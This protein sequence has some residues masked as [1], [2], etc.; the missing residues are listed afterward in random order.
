[1]GLFRNVLISFLVSMLAVTTAFAQVTILPAVGPDVDCEFILN[2]YEV[3]GEIPTVGE[4]RKAKHT[5]EFETAE[6]AYNEAAPSPDDLMA[7]NLDEE[8]E[9]CVRSVKK[10]REATK[11]YDKAKEA[12]ELADAT[13]DADVSEERDKLLGCAIQTGRISFAMIPYFIQRIINFLLAMVGLV[14]VLAIVIGGYFYVLGGLTDDKEKGKKYLMR[15]IM[16]L[17]LASLSWIIVSVIISL[18]T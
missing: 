7:C 17:A 5:K 12:K 16:G 4:V 1:M 9:E 8:L 18:V 11:K 15:A 14:S 10:L 2:K 3:D 6:K 13:A